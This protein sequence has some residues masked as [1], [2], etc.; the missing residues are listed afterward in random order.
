MTLFSEMFRSTTSFI[1]SREIAVWDDTRS[2]MMYRFDWTGPAYINEL[3]A[4][5]LEF[6]F[7][8][9]NLVDVLG[10][11][12]SAAHPLRLLMGLYLDSKYYARVVPPDLL[13]GQMQ[14]ARDAR[15]NTDADFYHHVD[16]DW[17]RSY[18]YQLE[19]KMPGT[20]RR[21]GSN[22]S[23]TS[24][25]RALIYLG[26]SKEDAEKNT[27]QV[28]YSAKF[29]DD[30]Y[31]KNWH[32]YHDQAP[33][34]ALVLR[35]MHFREDNPKVVYWYDDP[36]LTTNKA[37]TDL[38]D[39]KVKSARW[40]K[41]LQMLNRKFGFRFTDEDI[42]KFATWVGESLKTPKY[43]FRIVSGDNIPYYYNKEYFGSCMHENRATN[44]YE[45]QENVK[46]LVIEDEHRRY[47]GRALI[48]EGRRNNGTPVTVLDRVYPSD[49]GRHI[50][51]AMN[52]AKKEEWVYKVRHSIGGELSVDYR[53]TVSVTDNE[54][55]PYMD[56]FQWC[57]QPDHRGNFTVSNKSGQGHDYSLDST[58]DMCP[59]E[60]AY[61]C[62]E[63]GDHVHEDEVTHVDGSVF[64]ES[65]RGYY[66]VYDDIDG[67][68]VPRDDA[69]SL[70]NIT[71]T[72]YTH[73]DNSDV[74]YSNL[75]NVYY[76]VGR[77]LYGC[78]VETVEE[79]TY[80]QYE[81]DWT[82]NYTT[83]E[84]PDGHTWVVYE[85]DESALMELKEEGGEW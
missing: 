37:E 83:V 49:G 42:Q 81:G 44:F 52:Y 63:C 43:E 62:C 30:E 23:S 70:E 20:P 48:W 24:V 34:M 77:R 26:F 74:V 82:I 67:E 10:D 2:L 50:K 1:T 3:T 6:G 78:S 18:V 39:L 84:M 55:Y 15:C 80:G 13:L 21:W 75:D 73:V 66:F 69:V 64:C 22:L 7:T 61:S 16:N 45:D 51:A 36:A 41:F 40:P 47:V 5:D 65:C 31:R 32:Q 54:H 8:N 85:D 29:D 59:W 4:L 12:D 53:I 35:S 71:P 17:L 28:M 46:M 25:A 58:E 38:R 56:T 60:D 76:W 79:V 72:F 19:L 27:A 14:W 68:W 57:S 33:L 11:G 9:W